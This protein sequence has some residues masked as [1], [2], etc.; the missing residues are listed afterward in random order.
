ME[1]LKIINK[2]IEKLQVENY[3]EI[4]V[5]KGNLFDAV[6]A[7]RKTGVDPK[8]LIPRKKR[9]VDSFVSA[10]KIKYYEQ[11]SDDFFKSIEEKGKRMNLDVAFVDGLHTWQQAYKDVDNC[12]RHLN[13]NGVIMMH[14]CIPPHAAAAYPA[15][16]YDEAM[17]LNL[18]GWSGEWTGDVW[19]AVVQLRCNSQLETFVLDTDYGIGVV[20]KAPNS[21][22]LN[23][24][25]EEIEAMDY[26]FLLQNRSHLLNIRGMDYLDEIL[27]R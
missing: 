12:L 1:R 25:V 15:E 17:N 27:R 23:Y 3:L 11:K 10:G 7:K 22:K 26:D 6:R 14:D 16:S 18:S 8:F 4:G 2:V 5:F 20:L 13:Q 9:I 24:K 21:K 19:K